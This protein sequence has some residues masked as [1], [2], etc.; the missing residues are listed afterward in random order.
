MVMKYKLI[1]LLL[2][3]HQSHLTLRLIDLPKEN[4]AMLLSFPPRTNHKLKPLHRSIYGPYKKL[5]NSAS[6]IW[7]RS[8]PG[9][10]YGNL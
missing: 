5:L 4:G 3:Y 1:L 10:N 8:H 7:I 9:K 2:D 6:D